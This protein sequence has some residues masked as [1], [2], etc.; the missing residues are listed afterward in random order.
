MKMISHKRIGFIGLLKTK[1]K[2]AK[3]GALYLNMFQ[4]WCFTSNFAHHSNG[5]IIIAW[6]LNSYAVD[7]KG[8]TNQFIHCLVSSKRGINFAII[9]VYA[10]NDSNGR[11]HLW[12]DLGIIANDTK[13]PW[14]V[15]GDFNS[16]L[17]TKER[18]EYMVMPLKWCLFQNCVCDCGLEDVQYNGSY[19]T[20]NNKQEG[21]DRVYAKLDQVSA[22]NDRLEKFSMAEV[23][24]LPEG[25]FD[26]SPPLLSTCPSL[27]D[28]NKPFRYFNYWSSLREFIDIVKNGWHEIVA[29]SPMYRLVTKLKLLKS[30]FKGLNQ[31]GR[32]DIGVQDTEAY[33]ALIDIQ[34]A[35]RVQP[36]NGDLIAKEI[37]ARK[38]YAETHRNYLNFPRQKSKIA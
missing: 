37:Q 31:H 11:Q 1:V 32:D 34:L 15:C 35:L 25:D 22:N 6:N 2:A 20:C 13:P 3:M 17:S 26:H 10:L 24:F 7:I 8:G 38:H 4:G 29:G 21:K 5:L 19:F 33:K 18:L 30:G 36:G 16:V 27:H 28:K 23:T 12:N 9:V 14:I